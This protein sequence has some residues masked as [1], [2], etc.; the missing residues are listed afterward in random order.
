MLEGPNTESIILVVTLTVAVGVQGRPFAAPVGTPIVSAIFVDAK[1]SDAM[2]ALGNIVFSY[3]GT[4]AFMS[5]IAEMKKPEDYTK[6][7]LICQG[8]VT[9][10][11][12]VIGLIVYHFAGNYVSSPALASAGLLFK[13]ICYGLAIPALL[14]SAVIFTHVRLSHALLRCL[15]TPRYSNPAR[16]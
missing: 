8:F 10:V 5:I 11:Y 9:V 1:F 16:R 6:A 14:A 12:L 3:S 7:M 15:L 2:N 13:K 4:P